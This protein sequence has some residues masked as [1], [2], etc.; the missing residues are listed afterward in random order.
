MSQ[1][2]RTG[3]FFSAGIPSAH[4]NSVSHQGA[5][6]MIIIHERC[7]GIDVHKRSVVVCCL[8]NVQDGTHRQE[9]RT[10]GT[11]TSELLT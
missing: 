6:A 7:A 4:R 3:E 8:W 9:T 11:T 10:F 5:E 2:A 1:E